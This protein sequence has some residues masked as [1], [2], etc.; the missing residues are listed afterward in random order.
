ML[1]SIGK[2]NNFWWKLIIAMAIAFSFLGI[3]IWYLLPKTYL[4]LTLSPLI[5][6]LNKP[7]F[8]ILN[9]T[10]I[11]KLIRLISVRIFAEGKDNN[12][13]GSG[14]IISY[15]KSKNSY[16]VITNDHVISNRKFTYQIQTY[17]GRIYPIKIITSANTNLVE[18]DLALIE[19]TT[20]NKYQFISIKNDLKLNKGEP[21]F[22]GGF[23]FQEDFTQSKKLNITKGNLQVMLEKPLIGGYQFGYTNSIRNGMSG[24]ALINQKGE[25]I[26]LNGMGKNPL[27]GDPYVFKNG[28]TVSDEEWDK[29]SNLSW[30]IPTQYINKLIKKHNNE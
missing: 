5:P 10:E 4:S 18:D 27:F 29:M 23:P 6:N 21:V 26:A 1:C 7:N 13:G 28:E 22:A 12:R 30:G 20:E 24:G 16:L 25:L 17:D 3:I 14:V 15:N 2:N 9:E 11:N 19:F 8:T